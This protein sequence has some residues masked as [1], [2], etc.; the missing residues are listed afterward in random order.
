MNDNK[1]VAVLI[2][3]FVFLVAVLPLTTATQDSNMNTGGVPYSISNG[4]DMIKNDNHK[5]KGTPGT[6]K[7]LFNQNVKCWIEK[8][9]FQSRLKCMGGNEQF[10]GVALFALMVKIKVF[11]ILGRPW[12]ALALKIDNFWKDSN[13]KNK[14]LWIPGCPWPAP[15]FKIDI[16]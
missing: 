1:F 11:W 9:T 4:P 10:R 16:S 3:S 8:D 2:C 6:Y 15:A 7:T 14:A 12:P 5:W 13:K